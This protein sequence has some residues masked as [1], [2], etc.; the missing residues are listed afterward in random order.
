MASPA[1]ALGLYT[2]ELRNIRD[3]GQLWTVE[4]G[5]WSKYGHLLTC[6]LED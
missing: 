3:F 5:T 4:A 2:C 1:T 6:K